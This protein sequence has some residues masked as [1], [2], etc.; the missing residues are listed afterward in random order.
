M[1]SG[2]SVRRLSYT[3]GWPITERQVRGEDDRGAFFEPVNEVEE[4]L[5]PGLS[6]PQV[7][8]LVVLDEIEASQVIAVPALP[9][10]A[11]IGLEP[12]DQVDYLE[13]ADPG[14]GADAVS[15]DCEMTLAG[16]GSN[17][18]PSIALAR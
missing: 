13:E 10:V 14:S 9:A 4:Q 5:A 11:S 15:S 12:V 6:E 1:I 8:D 7:A 16:A 17:D 3:V 18:Q 2:R